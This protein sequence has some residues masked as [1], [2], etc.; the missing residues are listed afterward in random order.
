MPG[1]APAVPPMSEPAVLLHRF[2][3]PWRTAFVLYA[4]GLTIAT[5]WPRLALAPEVPASDKTLHML[6]FGALTYLLWR[7]RWLGGLLVIVLIAMGWSVLDEISQGIA[8]L[9]RHVTWLDGMANVLGVIIITAWLWA[10]QPVGGPVNRMRLALHRFAFDQLFQSWR[11]WL[12]FIGVLLACAVPPVIVWPLLSPAHTARVIIISFTVCL[13]V[14]IALLVRLWRGQCKVVSG[15]R[16][17]FAC[18]EPCTETAFNDVGHAPCPGCGADLHIA[19]WDDP[20]P[21]AA[22]MLMRI[23]GQPALLTFLVLSVAVVLIPASAQIFEWSIK[24]DPTSSAAPRIARFIGSLPP[25][26][27]AAID[28][29]LCLLLLAFATRLYRTRLARY[30]DRSIRCRKCG[31]DLRGTPTEQ[32]V[33]RCGECGTPFVRTVPLP[34]SEEKKR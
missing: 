13:M 14:S 4:M 24:A 28:L 8:Y 25:D 11:V 15:A 3:R 22:G 2:A 9:N 34:Q 33:G 21:P 31:H 32:G 17:C 20:S 16:P 29:S 27:T 18:G 19:Q 23:L 5:H 6:A 12:L 7:A 1:R 10:L 26:V 30:Y